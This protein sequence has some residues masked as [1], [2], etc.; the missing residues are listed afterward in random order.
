MLTAQSFVFGLIPR[1][2]RFF[3]GPARILLSLT[4]LARFNGFL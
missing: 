2:L 1:P 4:R 3:F